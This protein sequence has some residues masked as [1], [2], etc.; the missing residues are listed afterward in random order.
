M[1]ESAV[2]VINGVESLE[3]GEIALFRWC[4]VVSIVLYIQ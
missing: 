3:Y 4:Y 2:Q 1:N